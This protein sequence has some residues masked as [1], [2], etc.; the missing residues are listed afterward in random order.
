MH[1]LKNVFN[2]DH[3]ILF[4]KYLLFFA[5]F[6]I[7]EILVFLMGA[8]RDNNL[9][10]KC[11]VSELSAEVLITNPDDMNIG[12]CLAPVRTG[13]EGQCITQ[14]TTQDLILNITT[15]IVNINEK[16]SFGSWKCIHGTKRGSDT[17]E[18]SNAIPTNLKQCVSGMIN[19]I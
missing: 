7:A 2:I 17:L 5:D 8:F 16:Y 12:K 13:R 9:V 14:N 4:D 3:K 6:A 10:M 11:Y 18:I 15:V 1:L 19:I